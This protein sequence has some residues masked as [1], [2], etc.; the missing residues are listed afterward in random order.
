LCA[1]A[2]GDQ[3]QLCSPR[4]VF[5]VA[6]APEILTAWFAPGFAAP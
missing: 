6:V 5:V 3:H 1:M 2:T 4:I